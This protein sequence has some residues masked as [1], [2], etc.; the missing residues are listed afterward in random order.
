MYKNIHNSLFS[1]QRIYRKYQKYYNKT[2]NKDNTQEF[3]YTKQQKYNILIQ[4]Y[5]IQKYANFHII[6]IYKYTNIQIYKYKYICKPN[7]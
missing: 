7:K 2:K 4:I 3:K 1:T 6:Q 5:N